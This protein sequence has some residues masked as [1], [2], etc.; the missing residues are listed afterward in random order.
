MRILL[1]GFAILC[2]ASATVAV[3]GPRSQADAQASGPTAQVSATAEHWGAYGTGG[4]QQDIQLSP[5]AISLPG[6]IKQIS[7][8]NSTQYALLTNGTVYAWGIG[9]HGELGNNQTK[10]S[11]TRAVRVQFPKKV[12]IA[13]LPT[14]VMPYDTAFAVDTHGRVWGWGDN[15]DGELCLGTTAEQNIPA[16]LPAPITG[17]TTLDG[18]ANHATYDADGTLYSCGSNTYG[19][20]G[21]GNTT[22]STTPVEVQ[23]LSGANVS[24]LVASF[25]D[26]GALLTNGSY[27]DWGENN[28]GQLGNGTTGNSGVP[29]QASLP[30]GSVVTQV[31]QGGSF[32]GNGQT[33]VMLSTGA[34]YA[35]GNDSSYQLGDGQRVNEPSPEQISPPNGVT[36]QTLASGGSTSYAISTAGD[37]YAWGASSD[38]EVGDG[39]KTPALQPVEVESG[40]NLISST[41]ADVV[42]AASG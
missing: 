27:Y 30:P 8:S 23:D 10:N 29:V 25:G 37:V 39:K 12:K 9:T 31:A 7:S 6:P 42:V 33:L 17:V 32:T 40:V 14:D 35:W 11:F 26:T 13:F 1:N 21:D 3:A 41:A 18:G 15:V 4:Q 24:T 5:V 19:E 38:G 34:L 20:L 2:L 22:A 16:E 28:S 36:Y